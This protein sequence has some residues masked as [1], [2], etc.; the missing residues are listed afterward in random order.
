MVA[1]LHNTTRN[2]NSWEIFSGVDAVF[3]GPQVNIWRLQS[4]VFNTNCSIYLEVLFSAVR[5]ELSWLCLSKGLHYVLHIGLL[6]QMLALVSITTSAFFWECEASG[7]ALTPAS[8]EASFSEDPALT[9]HQTF[10][11]FLFIFWFL[12][13][14]KNVY[15]VVC[16]FCPPLV[17]SKGPR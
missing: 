12:S 17:I 1:S 2:L 9:S 16:L 8:F 10:L 14:G 13:W 11:Q 3:M 15:S 7:Q 5:T 4:K 6:E